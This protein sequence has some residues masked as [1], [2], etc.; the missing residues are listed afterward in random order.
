MARAR[1]GSR[2]ALLHPPQD[3]NHPLGQCVLPVSHLAA[4]SVIDC[5]SRNPDGPKVQE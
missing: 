4:V 3:V 5:G 2:M 1:M